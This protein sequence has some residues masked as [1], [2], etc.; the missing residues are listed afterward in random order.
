LSHCFGKKNVKWLYFLHEMWS[1]LPQGW[2]QLGCKVE[3]GAK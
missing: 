2:K 3:E 1:H